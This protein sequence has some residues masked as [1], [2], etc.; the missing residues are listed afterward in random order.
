[1]TQKILLA[2]TV[3]W[4]SAARL[5]GAFSVLGASVE[6]VLP[7]HHVLR[8]SRYLSRAYPYR[9]LHP[10]ASLA[11]GIEAAEPDLVV[12]CDD[13]ALSAL[14]ALTGFETLLTRSL[15]PL[16]GYAVLTA[17]APSIAAAREEGIAAPLTLAVDELQALP[18][19]LEHVGLP[20]VMKVD[21]SWGGGGV[22]LVRNTAEAEQTFR[23]LQGPPSRLRSLVR[24]VL[25]RD[26]HFFGEALQ[27]KKAVVNLQAFIQGKPATSAFACR[28]G[29]VLAAQHMDVVEWSGATGPARQM[30]RVHCPRM[31]EAAHRLAARFQLSGLHGLDFVRNAAGIPQL[32]EI[33][34]R[35]T[36]ICHLALDADLPAA[37]LGFPP[38]PPVTTRSLVALFPQLL[39]NPQRLP[40]VFYDSPW[41][42]QAVLQAFS[43][44]TR[45]EAHELELLPE[46]AGAEGKPALRQEVYSPRPR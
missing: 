21:G 1:V 7:G 40:A 2:T 25:R 6:A 35:A 19:A 39:A 20:C 4:P 3:D 9:A 44:G 17:R 10:L 41:D 22:K 31:E 27:P 38:R 18:E 45:G 16:A 42:D 32:I 30:Q 8:R 46:W 29:E 13:R 34:P 23:Q 26:P 43:G 14:L 36:Q 33:N 5:A 24:A 11:Q 12:P 37:L 28:G 15:G